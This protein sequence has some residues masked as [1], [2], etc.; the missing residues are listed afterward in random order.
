MILHRKS[1][2]RDTVWTIQN[3]DYH[4]LGQGLGNITWFWTSSRLLPQVLAP[5]SSHLTVCLVQAQVRS[6]L[7][8]R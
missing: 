2:N 8:K 7:L 6:K 5:N 4:H 1:R 3:L